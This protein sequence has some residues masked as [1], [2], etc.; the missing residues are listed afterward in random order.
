MQ[1]GELQRELPLAL[2]APAPG[3]ADGTAAIRIGHKEK[4][5]VPRDLRELRD[6]AQPAA[7]TTT[8]DGREGHAPSVTRA[9]PSRKFSTA[10]AQSCAA[11]AIFGPLPEPPEPEVEPADVLEEAVEPES[12]E[13]LE[14]EEAAPDEPPSFFVEL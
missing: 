12:D 7:T 4:A 14:L 9:D 8:F 10:G 13:V 5:P 3:R 11:A 6:V 2:H 1:F